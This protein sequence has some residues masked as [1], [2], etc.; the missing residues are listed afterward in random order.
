MTALNYKYQNR[1]RE[2]HLLHIVPLFL[3][4]DLT[5]VYYFLTTYGNWGLLL[6]L[7]SGRIDRLIQRLETNVWVSFSF[8]IKRYIFS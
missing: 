4:A 5:K 2:K 6:D 8:L 7:T 3:S 1:L